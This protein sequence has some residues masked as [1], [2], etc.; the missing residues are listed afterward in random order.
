M[1]V[2]AVRAMETA[3]GARAL[4]SDV[5]RAW[6][7]RA[8]AEV[9]GA[10]A[11]P[12][13]FLARRATLVIERLGARHPAWPRAVH[14][15]RWRPWCGSVVIGLAFATGA[16]LDQVDGAKRINIL[17]PP[18]LGLL[19]WNLVVYAVLVV[20]YV[21]RY[22]EAAAPGPLRV[23]F[24]RIG[25][26]AIRQ[27]GAG[28][29]RQIIVAFA[30]DW[31]RRAAPLYS[32]R[33]ARILHLAAA[34]LAA[35]VLGGLYVRGLALEYHASWESTFL[36]A[37]AVRAIV[38]FAYGPGAYVTGIPVPAVD[39]I[40]AIR[41][42]GG[43]NAAR[44]LHLMAATIGLVVIVP[45]LLL[46]GVA[47]VIEGHR[48][49]RLP[50]ALD[51]AYFRRLLRGYR[52]GPAQIRV[53]PYSYAL[54]SAAVAGLGALVARA[55]GGSAAML[56]VAPVAYG[57]DDAFADVSSAGQGST[58]IAVFSATAT[59]EREVHGA[60]LED[61]VRRTVGAEALF[62]LIDES[63]WVARQGDEPARLEGRRTA[64]RQVCD[65]AR[66]PAVFVDLAIPDLA[67]VDAA[68]DAAIGDRAR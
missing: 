48:A 2:V 42:P 53:I 22:G 61:L 21:V 32:A 40:A 56:V 27:R 12:G 16:F 20:G 37:P 4:W 28:G 15:L 57:T 35:G 25:R 66:V 55:F 38:A 68:L 10:D 29:L 26:G 17:A 1:N 13:A 24:A 19:A 59:P 30:E 36:D 31:T 3:D 41:V 9:V 6:A 44:W 43:E 58:L 34:V 33:T 18:V 39:S 54:P 46:A 51:D 65:G 64:W 45:R 60:F 14:S 50:I 67:S 62:A 52:G 47:G 49:A 11:T 8:A 7:S 63:A 5:D 23:A